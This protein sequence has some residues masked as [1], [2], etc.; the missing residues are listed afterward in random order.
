[1][2]L[3]GTQGVGV[4]SSSDALK[5]RGEKWMCQRNTRSQAAP[6]DPARKVGL[7]PTKKP[8]RAGDTIV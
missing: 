2:S 6:G 4:V 8:K 3:V 5:R 7:N 1:M